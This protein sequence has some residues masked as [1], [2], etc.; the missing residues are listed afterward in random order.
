MGVYA[1]TVDG[2]SSMSFFAENQADGGAAHSISDR[3]N[4][5]L[6]TET[7]AAHGRASL[8]SINPGGFSLDWSVAGP[9]LKRSWYLAVGFS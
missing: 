9:Y 7:G 5:N 6:V 8:H 3:G 1:L 4:L 2:V